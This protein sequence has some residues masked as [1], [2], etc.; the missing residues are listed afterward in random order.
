M[1]HTNTPDAQHIISP[2][3]P[4]LLNVN[5][6]AFPEPESMPITPR[7][8]KKFSQLPDDMGIIKSQ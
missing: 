4:G 3:A 6:S 1:I 5:A 2:V 7:L 8:R